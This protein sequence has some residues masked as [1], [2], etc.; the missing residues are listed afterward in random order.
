MAYF[1]YT[2][3]TKFRNRTE[4]ELLCSV[5]DSFNSAWSE[6]ERAV[7]NAAKQ[8]CFTPLPHAML[9]CWQTLDACINC[10][11]NISGLVLLKNNI[12]VSTAADLWQK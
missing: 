3:Q 4:S 9:A 8:N 2:L 1:A 7:L 10:S 6:G 12:S 11:T 5:P